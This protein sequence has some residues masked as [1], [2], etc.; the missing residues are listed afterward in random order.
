MEPF[1]F[2]RIY[3]AWWRRNVAADGVA[4]ISRSAERYLS[5]ALDDS[6]P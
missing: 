3:G 1:R 2:D 4:A 5:F 6:V